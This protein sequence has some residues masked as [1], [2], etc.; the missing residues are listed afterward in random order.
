MATYDYICSNEH[1]YVEE[2]PMTAEQIVT[3]CPECGELLRRVFNTT[4]IMF[5][6]RGFYSTGG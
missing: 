2:R 3:N 1:S 6:G 5:K 4:P